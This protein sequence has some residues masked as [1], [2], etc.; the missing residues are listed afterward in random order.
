MSLIPRLLHGEDSSVETAQQTARLQVRAWVVESLDDL[1]L[2]YRRLITSCCT[3]TLVFVT[4][5]DPLSPWTPSDE[6]RR[7][8]SMLTSWKLRNGTLISLILTVILVVKSRLLQD[9]G[10]AAGQENF[11]AARLPFALDLALR[12]GLIEIYAYAKH[13]ATATFGVVGTLR[14]ELQVM[15]TCE[16]LDFNFLRTLQVREQVSPAFRC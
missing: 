5:V 13:G 8:T 15:R 14:W 6:A 10:F 11:T 3:Y 7:R 1:M 4:R 2:K 16:S 12:S 9:L